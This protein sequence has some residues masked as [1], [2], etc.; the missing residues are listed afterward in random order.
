MKT[1]ERLLVIAGATYCVLLLGAGLGYRVN[2]TDSAPRGLW[3]VK[4]LDQLSLKRGSLVSICPPDR[5][6]VRAVA[7]LGGLPA[8]D[9]PNTHLAPFLKPVGAVSGD[10]VRLYKGRSVTVN[11]V[12]LPNTISKDSLPAFPDGE[13]TVEDGQV[14]LFSNYNSNSFDSRYFGPVPTANLRGKAKP[15]LTENR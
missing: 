9:C 10:V 7:D 5:P 8:G 14:W 13:Y 3:T 1:P 2:F 11:G 12:P 6:I 4:P 15:L